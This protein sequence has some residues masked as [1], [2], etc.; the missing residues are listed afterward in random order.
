[1]SAVRDG[2]VT[3]LTERGTPPGMARIDSQA[4]S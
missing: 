4:S 2:P 1:M 3:K